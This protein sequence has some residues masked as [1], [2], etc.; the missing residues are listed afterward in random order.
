[1]HQE[2]KD[3]RQE[4][5]EDGAKAERAKEAKDHGEVKAREKALAV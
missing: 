1:M 3:I 5:K 4:E 2:E